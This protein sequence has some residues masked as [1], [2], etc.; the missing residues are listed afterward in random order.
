[1]LTYVF[2]P[3]MCHDKPVNV[4]LTVDVRFQRQ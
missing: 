2:R 3:A 1:V 4:Y